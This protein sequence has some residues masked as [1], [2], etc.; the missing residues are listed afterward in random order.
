MSTAGPC[1]EVVR[2]GSV[3][4][5]MGLAA[6]SLSNKGTSPRRRRAA[7]EE[8]RRVCVNATSR[9]SDR[10]NGPPCCCPCSEPP[11]ATERPNTEGTTA[12]P[13]DAATRW[14]MV[15]VV[16]EVVGLV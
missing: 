6:S 16:E 9:P 2:A 1:V 4:A 14:S 8:E 10:E 13:L 15:G 12:V 11:P 7:A 5:A 3:V